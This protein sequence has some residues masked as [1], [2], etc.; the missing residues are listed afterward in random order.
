MRGALGF[1]VLR[2]WLFFRSVFLVFV[3]QNFGFS[4][5]VFIAVRGFSVIQAL[6]FGFRNK[7]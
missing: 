3:P 5:L 7:Y 4:V 6:V 1:S 2:F